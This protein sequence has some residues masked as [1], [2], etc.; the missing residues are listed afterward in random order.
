MGVDKSGFFRPT[1]HLYGT[2]RTIQDIQMAFS[3]CSIVICLDGN[4]VRRKEL[5]NGT[6]KEGRERASFNVHSDVSNLLFFLTPLDNV[7]IAGDRF[8]ESDDILFSLAKRISRSNP[9]SETYIF[10]GDDDLLQSIDKNI[11]VLRTVDIAKS[12]DERTY[13]SDPNMIKK[14]NQCPIPHLP[15]YRALIGDSSDAIKGIPR[16]PRPFAVETAKLLYEHGIA[17]IDSLPNSMWRTRLQES[18][19]LISRNI[20]LMKLTEVDFAIKSANATPKPLSKIHEDLL[21]LRLT[22][23]ANYLR[24]ETA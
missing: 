20:E 18:K 8:Q 3:D 16:I 6:Y 15:Y 12:I 17:G 4:P 10:S 9:N 1:G 19:D 11:F 23:Y 14:Y 5:T 2:L 21:D 13:L 7:Y 22:R 24:R